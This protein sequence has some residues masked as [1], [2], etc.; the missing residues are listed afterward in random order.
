MRLRDSEFLIEIRPK[1]FIGIDG[2]EGAVYFAVRSR[3]DNA[4][5]LPDTGCK[6]TNF[7]SFGM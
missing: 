3:T 7:T 5:V 6:E 2:Q 1:E 4:L